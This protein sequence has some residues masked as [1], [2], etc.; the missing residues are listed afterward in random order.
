MVPTQH[1]AWWQTGETQLLEPSLDLG[2]QEGPSCSWLSIPGTAQQ[3][4][5]PITSSGKAGIWLVQYTQ[6]PD[7]AA[8]PELL[9]SS[10]LGGNLACLPLQRPY[11]SIYAVLNL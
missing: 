4:P 9:C 2:L 6:E 1:S 3:P 11:I 10:S 5:G 8:V 7:P